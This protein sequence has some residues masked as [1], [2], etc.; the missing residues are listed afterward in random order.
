MSILIREEEHSSDCICPFCGMGKFLSMCTHIEGYTLEDTHIFQLIHEKQ[1]YILVNLEEVLE[2]RW[3]GKDCT[4]YIAQHDGA[5][6]ECFL[7]YSILYNHTGASFPMSVSSK[8]YYFNTHCSCETQTL[9]FFSCKSQCFLFIC[10]NSDFNA[11]IIAREE[12]LEVGD[13]AQWYSA[14]LISARP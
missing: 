14:C 2:A 4:F 3:Y 10:F 8:W 12:H 7:P 1:V 5:H 9:S 11:S 6:Q 13:L